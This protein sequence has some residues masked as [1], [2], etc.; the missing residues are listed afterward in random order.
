MKSSR[1]CRN[2]IIATMV[3]AAMGQS[4]A[5]AQSAPVVAAAPASSAAALP[6]DSLALSDQRHWQSFLK[7]AARPNAVVTLEDIKRSFRDETVSTTSPGQYGMPNA[8]AYVVSIPERLRELFPGRKQIHL[9]FY[10]HDKDLRTCLTK[11]ELVSDLNRAQ[12]R[13]LFAHPEF[14]QPGVDGGPPIN[15]P[16]Q[17][18]FL[19]GDQGVISIAYAGGC[20]ESAS[21]DANKIYF[22]LL[23]NKWTSGIGQ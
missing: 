16:A 12:W 20:P 8:L 22:D 14:V 7:L 3:I 1:K 15:Y 2:L 9:D 11:E 10:F 6:G 5:R 13:Q 21:L 4:I 18:I 17:T 23:T 19:K